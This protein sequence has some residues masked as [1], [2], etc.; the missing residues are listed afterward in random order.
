MSLSQLSFWVSRKENVSSKLGTWMK[1]V[2]SCNLLKRGVWL[3]LIRNK[4]VWNH[5]LGSSALNL[6][7]LNSNIFLHAIILLA[8]K[9]TSAETAFPW[10]LN[11]T[12]IRAAPFQR[13]QTH[14][15]KSVTRKLKLQEQRLISKLMPFLE[16]HLTFIFEGACPLKRHQKCSSKDLSNTNL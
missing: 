12:H 6:P 14:T 7:L 4:I 13:Q 15:L 8:C 11:I 9:L 16:F 10:A 5:Y 2:T 1:A 3:P